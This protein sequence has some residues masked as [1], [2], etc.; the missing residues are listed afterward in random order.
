M[1]KFYQPIFMLDQKFTLMA[2]I[3]SVLASEAGYLAWTS[4]IVAVAGTIAIAGA[5]TA[6]NSSYLLLTSSFDGSLGF[7]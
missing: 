4:C 2:T 3:S 1:V 5:I 7:C 6:K